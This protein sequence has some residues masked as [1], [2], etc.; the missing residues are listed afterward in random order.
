LFDVV[1]ITGLPAFI[2]R[3]VWVNPSSEPLRIEMPKPATRHMQADDRTSDIASDPKG[4]TSG[5][6][7]FD[8]HVSAQQE[9]VGRSSPGLGGLE[10]DR[11]LELSGL[12]LVQNSTAAN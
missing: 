10:I 3:A 2:T 7:L 12:L 11:Q 1:T 8:H 9:D 5:L 4:A 6:G